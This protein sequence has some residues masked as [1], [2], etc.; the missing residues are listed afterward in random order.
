[1]SKD[2][3]VDKAEKQWEGIKKG[4]THIQQ[5]YKLKTLYEQALTETRSQVIRDVVGIVKEIFSD[6]TKCGNNICLEKK[7]LALIDEI[8]ALEEES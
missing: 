2:K 3:A 6:E 4:F 5:V 7:A 1:M 8:N